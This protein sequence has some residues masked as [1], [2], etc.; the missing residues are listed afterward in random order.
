MN[1][2]SSAAASVKQ[3]ELFEIVPDRPL[4]T[5]E[6]TGGCCAGCMTGEDDTLAAWLRRQSE[7]QLNTILE[8]LAHNSGIARR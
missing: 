3:L 8:S 1:M 7:E 4:P 2:Q 5:P 6:P